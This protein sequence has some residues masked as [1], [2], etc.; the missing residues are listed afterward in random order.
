MTGT[1]L[2]CF[3]EDSVSSLVADTK[4]LQRDLRGKRNKEP[5]P[6]SQL[7]HCHPGWLAGALRLGYPRGE[8]CRSETLMTIDQDYITSHFEQWPHRLLRHSSCMQLCMATGLK[9]M[10]SI[11]IFRQFFRIAQP[12]KWTGTDCAGRLSVS[13]LTNQAAK[14]PF[15]AEADWQG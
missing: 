2:K 8:Q 1:W 3:S 10:A 9:H 6:A 13:C 15:W 12:W 14:F 11:C 4:P 5:F 7:A